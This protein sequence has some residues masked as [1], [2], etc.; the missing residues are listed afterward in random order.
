ML[1]KINNHTV[2]KQQAIADMQ[3]II[4]KAMSEELAKT[5]KTIADPNQK[6]ETIVIELLTAAKIKNKQHHK[7]QQ[8]QQY[9]PEMLH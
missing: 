6:R 4:E 1:E 9:P 5:I 3:V 2:P 7:Q 8:Q